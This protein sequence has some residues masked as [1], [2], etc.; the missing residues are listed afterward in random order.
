MMEHAEQARSA[1]VGSTPVRP[2]VVLT[3]PDTP[4]PQPLLS[5]L[6][7]RGIPVCLV[8]DPPSV[9]AELARRPD[10]V[11]VVHE[12]QR[13]PCIGELM[14]AVRRYHPDAK[15]WQ[16]AVDATGSA[17]LTTLPPSPPATE[18]TPE[19]TG[20]PRDQSRTRGESPGLTSADLTQDE[21]NL[22][23]GRQ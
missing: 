9:M 8:V 13:Q 10:Q 20:T 2:F 14:E 12:P 5:L 7:R 4:R 22:L 6:E 17:R 3:Q 21:L 19:K 11:I 1:D 15:I 16:Y 18:V 23:L